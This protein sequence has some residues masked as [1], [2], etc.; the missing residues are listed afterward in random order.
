MILDRPLMPEEVATLRYWKAICRECFG[1]SGRHTELWVKKHVHDFDYT[2]NGCLYHEDTLDR[3]RPLF[4]PEHLR[5]KFRLGKLNGLR[6]FYKGLEDVLWL[7]WGE[8]YERGFPAEF[9]WDAARRNIKS[10]TEI[11]IA[12]NRE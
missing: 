12:Q 11:F 3:I 9:D 8:I 7:E 5:E 2:L 4:V 6:E 10:L 1:W